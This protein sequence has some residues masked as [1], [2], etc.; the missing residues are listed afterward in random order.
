MFATSVCVLLGAVCMTEQKPKFLQPGR[1]GMFS[2]KK[3]SRKTPKKTIMGSLFTFWIKLFHGRNS[4]NYFQ[5]DFVSVYIKIGSAIWNSGCRAFKHFSVVLMNLNE[6]KS[7]S[8]LTKLLYSRYTYNH[9][10]FFT[11]INF[12]WSHWRCWRW[13]QSGCLVRLCWRKVHFTKIL[14]LAVLW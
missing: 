1:R 9:D 14:F 10:S 3:S 8:T 5:M 7:I 11:F 6:K 12:I 4:L 13:S 2:R